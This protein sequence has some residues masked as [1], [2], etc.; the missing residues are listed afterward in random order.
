[1]LRVK[2]NAVV[3]MLHP[4]AAAVPSGVPSVS[5]IAFPTRAARPPRGYRSITTRGALDTP[6][7]LTADTAA[8]IAGSPPGG[9]SDTSR[10]LAG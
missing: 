3:R 10:A 5:V 7:G 1:M 6:V 2:R 4:R 8:W 9:T